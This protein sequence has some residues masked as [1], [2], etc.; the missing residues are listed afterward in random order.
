[1]KNFFK[2]FF[3]P[4]RLNGRRKNLGKKFWWYYYFTIIA[5]FDQ[6]YKF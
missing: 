4:M 5:H 2:N 1:M 6:H 3:S